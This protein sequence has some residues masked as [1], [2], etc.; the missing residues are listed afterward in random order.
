MTPLFG[1][2]AQ[3]HRDA[4]VAY[5][6]GQIVPQHTVPAGQGLV[7]EQDLY[8]FLLIDNQVSAQVDTSRVAM[9]MASVQQYLHAILNGM[10]PGYQGVFDSKAQQEW[11][12]SK[13]EYAVWAANQMLQDYPENYVDPGLRIKQTQG[14]REFVNDINQS[15]ISADSVQKAL[16]HYLGKFEHISNLDVLSGYIDGTD[17][18]HADYYL[19]G[20]QNVEPHAY[21]WRKVSVR[22]AAEDTAARA[23][24]YLSPT[25]WSEWLPVE[26]PKGHRVLHI[27]PLLIEGRLHVAWVEHRLEQK[28][29]PARRADIP[30]LF[31]EVARYSINLAYRSLDGSWSVPM[32][33]P[34]LSTPDHF[35]GAD[36]FAAFISESDPHDKRIV[37]AYGVNNQWTKDF[38]VIVLNTR[39][40]T[41]LHEAVGEVPTDGGY[42]EKIVNALGHFSS[43]GLEFQ[44][45]LA[46][47]RAARTSVHRDP[48]GE[49]N[50]PGPYNGRLSLWAG[51]GQASDGSYSLLCQGICDLLL[52]GWTGEYWQVRRGVL[53]LTYHPSQGPEQTLEQEVLLNGGAQMTL[54]QIPLGKDFDAIPE[55]LVLSFSLGPDDLHGVV[56]FAVELGA[57]PAT[58][59]SIVAQPDGS[60]FLDLAALD[61]QGLRYV[62]LNTLFARE[63]VARAMVSVD[64]LLS[65]DT[66]HIEEPPLP[67]SSA[68]QLMDFHGANGRYFWEL[69]FHIPHAVAWR[70]HHE[71][72][73]LAAEQWL[74][75]LFNPQARIKPTYPPSPFYWSVR[76]LEE[77][78]RGEYEVD[79]ITDPDAICY[80]QPVH[81]RKAIFSF[82]VR[83]LLAYGDL[84]YRRLT[85]DALTEAQLMYTRALN[86]LGPKP[87]NRT[88]GRWEPVN[89]EQAAE[90]DSTLLAGIDA[91]LPQGLSLHLPV[92][93][94]PWL[95]L[96]D[97][98]RF[99]LP[100]NTELLELWDQ[101]ASRLNNLRNNRTLDGKPLMVPLY[102][103]ALDPKDLLRAQNSG[104][105]LV[106]RSVGS[107]APIPPFRFR[108]LLP[109]LQNAVETLGRFGEQVRL[110]REMK[111]RALQEELQQSHVLELSQFSI[112]LQGAAL[113][114]AEAGLLALEASRRVIDKRL[115]H[116]QALAAENISSTEQHV[117]DSY[118]TSTILGTSA[119]VM[120]IAAG[121]TQMGSFIATAFGGGHI[122]VG[123]AVLAASEGLD[124][125]A[126]ITRTAADRLGVT[127]QYRRRLE[128]WT[129]QRDLAEAELSAI[130]EQI[131]GQRTA[132]DMARIQLA[133]VRKGEQQSQDYYRFLKTRSTNADLYQWLLGQM[134]TFYFQAYDAVV[135]LCLNGEACWQYEMGDYQTRFIQPNV[136]FDNY[137]G[138]TAGDALRLQLLRMES[139]YL[140]RFER[141]QELVRTVSLKA[142]FDS[143]AYPDTN[144]S[145]VL[146]D[147]AEG[148]SGSVEFELSA[149]LFDDDYPGHFLRQLVS[150][151]VTL[152]ALVGPYQD[153]RAVLTQ[154]SSRTV[155]K[156]DPRAMNHLYGKPDSDT[157]QIL[158]NPRA[159]QSICLSRGLDDH[160]VFQ[161]DFNDE[162]YLPFEGTGALSRWELRFP[163]HGSAQ[164]QV[165]LQSLTDI[166]VQVR[167]TALDGGPDFAAHV[168]GLLGG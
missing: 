166:I 53:R 34:L 10:E 20:Q 18:R 35:A 133:Q 5:Y 116:F 28:P 119:Q 135:A 130:D 49:H 149:R 3:D 128:E 33:I 32:T 6:L 4:L 155:L 9:G 87:D 94:G 55:V 143:Q 137:Y 70:L 23:D 8:E 29:V 16:Q 132:I 7:T 48:D 25:A 2:L 43:N 157:R 156:A 38:E 59:P 82:Y 114:H 163:H 139:A 131:A 50:E 146:D 37:L 46:T 89:L 99:R 12:S 19:I 79:G 112:Q 51:F 84:L 61:L 138:L 158:Y 57:L 60:Q 113:E 80:S 74:H 63:L 95:E 145:A 47:D 58:R 142:L 76:P 1:V 104:S 126:A 144:W 97:S 134:S 168:E 91:T 42:L 108:A 129:L 83:N 147:L 152:P 160:G 161:L 103:P 125:V 14:F 148:E 90:P 105:G 141:R 117:M 56:Q 107:L 121:A 71:F 140:K 15:R 11:R 106:Q 124:M 66:Q 127:E 96:L 123:A 120:Q 111:D 24:D 41:V 115:G 75:Y 92:S 159:S 65:W 165:V 78:G 109:R 13:S 164:Q 72:D 151:S 30:G 27:R 62:R 44:H 17:F 154:I 88:V 93:S 162:R 100:V 150:V 22:F 153:V 81:Y 102:A 85:R 45:P 69:F 110:Y 36:A 26:I 68:S 73:Y 86:L 64:A 167:Y 40:G 21:Y 101:L 67:G 98:P 77:E 39:F 122:R 54:M 52:M 136:W 31:E 118:L